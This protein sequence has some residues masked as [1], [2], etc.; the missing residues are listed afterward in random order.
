MAKKSREVTCLKLEEV[1]LGTVNIARRIDLRSRDARNHRTTRHCLNKEEE[2]D[3]RQDIVMGRERHEPMHHQIMCP[4]QK[5]QY[6]D[7]KNPQHE[8]ED[9]VGV[10]AEIGMRSRSL[11]WI[12]AHNLIV[13]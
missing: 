11:L 12:L 4:D 2:R 7:G 3:N 9:G 5:N 10:V 1:S 13:S 6:V 8:D